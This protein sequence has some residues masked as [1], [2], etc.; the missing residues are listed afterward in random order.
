MGNVVYLC[1]DGEG[2][3]PSHLRKAKSEVGTISS[4]KIKHQLTV[5]LRQM[6]DVGNGTDR[7]NVLSHSAIIL[8]PLP[9]RPFNPDSTFRGQRW[10]ERGNAV[11]WS[12]ES[13]REVV[14]TPFDPRQHLR[15]R[16][17]SSFR[18]DTTR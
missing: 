10:D 16:S 9:T 4:L 13:P 7:D 6:K 11:G 18:R 1:T 5:H 3:D 2:Q 12:D 8:A 15:T 17:L 14:V